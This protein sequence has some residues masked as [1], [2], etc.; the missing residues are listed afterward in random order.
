MSTGEGSGWEPEQGG[1]A[2]SASVTGKCREPTR[3]T[4]IDC[5][6]KPKHDGM[7]TRSLDALSAPAAAPSESAVAGLPTAGLAK[8]YPGR[9]AAPMV[10]VAPHP[11]PLPR[12]LQSFPPRR[13]PPARG[14]PPPPLLLPPA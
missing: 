13:P 1:P 2:P 11:R 8:T 6:E 10:A 3:H 5:A 12:P 4:L 9:G 7:F 14:T